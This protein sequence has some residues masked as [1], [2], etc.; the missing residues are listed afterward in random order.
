V[1]GAEFAIDFFYHFKL[2]IF[3]LIELK[4]TPNRGGQLYTNEFKSWEFDKEVAWDSS[5]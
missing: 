4:R 1:E 3:I 5:F 2:K